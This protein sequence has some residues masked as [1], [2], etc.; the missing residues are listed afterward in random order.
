MLRIS[1]ISATVPGIC[2]QIRYFLLEIIQEN[3][4]GYFCEHC[5]DVFLSR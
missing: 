1:I 2:V 3:K 4:R 5:V